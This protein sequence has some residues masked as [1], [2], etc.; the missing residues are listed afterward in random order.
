VYYCTGCVELGR[1]LFA[2]CDVYCSGYITLYNINRD[3]KEV[4]N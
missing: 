1:K 2:P 3:L 4:E